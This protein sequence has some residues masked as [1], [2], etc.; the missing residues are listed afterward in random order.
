MSVFRY[1]VEPV[2]SPQ[3]V[4]SHDSVT[5]ATATTRT[6]VLFCCTVMIFL[7]GFQVLVVQKGVLFCGNLIIFGFRSKN[8][9]WRTV[10]W[11]IAKW[12]SVV[13]LYHW[14]NG[15]PFFLLENRWTLHASVNSPSSC[16]FL[17]N[18]ADLG[19]VKAF[20]RFHSFGPSEL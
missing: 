20:E 13:G 16:L 11:E 10:F 5:R 8:E 12:H 17:A 15:H 6:M 18:A 3:S 19:H 7:H 4:L 14:T 2:K 1:R 9:D